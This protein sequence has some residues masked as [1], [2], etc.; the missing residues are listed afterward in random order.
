[1]EEKGIH[2]L[3][4]ARAGQGLPVGCYVSFMSCVRMHQNSRASL[5]A[6]EKEVLGKTHV[7]NGCII[8]YC[9]I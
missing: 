7:Y 2:P 4:P 3:T 5:T 9:I 6:R 8:M 1:M